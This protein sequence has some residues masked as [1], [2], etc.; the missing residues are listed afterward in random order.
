[1]GC[2]PLSGLLA[3]I[4]PGE[5]FWCLSKGKLDLYCPLG[6]A[7]AGE[8]PLQGEACSLIPVAECPLSSQDSLEVRLGHPQVSGEHSR[9][10]PLLA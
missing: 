6:V 1:L 5:R 7:C 8:P 3:G 10:Q 9:R 2:S 4:R